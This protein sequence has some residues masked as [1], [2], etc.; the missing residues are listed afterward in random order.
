MSPM[1]VSA[2]APSRDVYTVTR[3]NREV[4][5]V[6]EGSFPTL[7]VQGEISNLARPASGH[8][9]FSLKDSHS[10]VRCAMFRN[11]NRLLKFSP[12]NGMEVITLAA[13]SLYEGRGEFQLVVER[14]EPAGVGALQKAF[15]ELK[16]RLD[17][18]G[19]FAAARKRPLPAFPDTVGVV[20]SP[21]GA[22]VRDILHVLNRRWPRARVIVYP[23]PVQG[24]G[25]GAQIAR[26]LETAGRRGE[27]DVLILAR[28]GGSLE[29]L[30]AFNEE[31]VARAVFDSPVPVV[32]GVGHETDFTI[33]DFVADL[34]APTPS[35]AAEAVSP[36]RVELAER[37]S[38]VMNKLLVQTN[39]RLRKYGELLR[40]YEKRLPQPAR[41]LQHIS[42][43]LD[44][45][46]LRLL[47]SQKTMI[48]VKRSQLLK[49]QA[50]ISHYNPRHLLKYH[51][52][53]CRHLGEQLH[54]GMARRLMTLKERLEHTAHNLHTVSPL[55]TLERGYAIVTRVEDNRI[56][57]EAAS[58]RPG[59]AIRTRL[60][61]GQIHSTVDKVS[62]AD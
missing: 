35:A 5:A 24:E 21:S 57:R 22:A 59:D 32:T 33:A 34:R 4:R 20:T 60:A 27:A 58:L 39:H 45:L 56:I 42:Q 3:L 48:A 14:M 18:E 54:T 17:K 9:Y 38:G 46:S 13:V 51:D 8:L 55:V 10:Q 11:R 61:R 2:D 28:G 50:G 62:D 6:L 47:Q 15:E 41:R 19:L 49:L 26:A 12:E 43:H 40:Y 53:R 52:S 36:D 29:D 1:T 7:W 16:S 23:V 37:V 44:G 31:A 30:W 25:A